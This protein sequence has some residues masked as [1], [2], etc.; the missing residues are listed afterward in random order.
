MFKIVQKFAKLNT[1]EIL[2]QQ[3]KVLQLCFSS[4]VE[5]TTEKYFENGSAVRR[6]IEASSCHFI[7]NVFTSQTIMRLEEAPTTK[8]DDEWLHIHKSL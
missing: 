3:Q 6:E 7:S 1:Q 4:L 8:W 5:T 2:T